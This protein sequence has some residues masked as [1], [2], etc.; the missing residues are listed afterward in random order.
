MYICYNAHIGKEETYLNV[1]IYINY[2]YIC[3]D[4]ISALTPGPLGHKIH[5]KNT[6]IPNRT[7]DA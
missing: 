3:A 7:M 2:I 1:Y 6:Q 5:K 4:L